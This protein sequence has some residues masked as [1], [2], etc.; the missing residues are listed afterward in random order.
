VTP[1][2]IPAATRAGTW[3]AETAAA[4]A[5]SANSDRSTKRVALSGPPAF[6][7]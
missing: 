6:R 4:G 5:I 7:Y 1:A 3:A 2:E